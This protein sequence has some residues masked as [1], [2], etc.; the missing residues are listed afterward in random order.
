MNKLPENRDHWK[1]K[2]QISDFMSADKWSSDTEVKIELFASADSNQPYSEV[3]VDVLAYKDGKLFI[4]EIGSM[5]S[6]DRYAKLGTLADRF[7]HLELGREPFRTHYSQ[8]WNDMKKIRF[9]VPNNEF[10]PREKVLVER[11]KPY[12]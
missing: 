2:K 5:T 11:I 12:N 9:E 4:A 7:E 3:T 6:I 8:K 1:I 10:K